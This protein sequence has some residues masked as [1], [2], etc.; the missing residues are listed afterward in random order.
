MLAGAYVHVHTRFKLSSDESIVWFGMGSFAL[1]LSIQELVKLVI[2]KRHVNDIRTIFMFVGL[3]TVLIDTQI[4][5][6]V[7][8]YQ[9]VCMSLQSTFVMAVVEIVL[10]WS[11]VLKL[12]FEMR[13]Y[14]HKL[15]RRF[16]KRP[17]NLAENSVSP[18][19]TRTDSRRLSTRLKLELEQWRKRLQL[20][21]AAEAFADMSAEYIAIGCSA[22]FL[23]AFG[24]HPN[25]TL[26]IVVQE[27]VKLVI[28]KRRVN[29]I[30]TI[31]L[32][33]GLPTV[34]IDT[35]IRLAMQRYQSASMSLLSSVLMAVVE[36]TLRWVKVLKLFLEMQYY[37]RR[38]VRQ[39]GG[40]THSIARNAIS[41]T[42]ND[43]ED[44]SI[45]ITVE[46]Q[47]WRQRLHLFHD[48]EVFADMS[49][50]YIAIGCSALFLYAF[51]HHPKY[52]LAL[53]TK[54]GSTTANLFGVQ[55]TSSAIVWI[56]LALEVVIDL[57]STTLE[58]PQGVEFQELRKHRAYIAMSFLGIGLLNVQVS[59]LMYL[60]GDASAE[61]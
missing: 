37:E 56:Q 53:L 21:H 31:F 10:R 28:L 14:E 20:F 58:I 2:L 19:S 6:V 11:K 39:L 48:A 52:E 12:V 1:K 44:K 38:L 4:R 8:R 26:K 13:Y 33:V 42:A 25:F 61:C 18:T 54:H 27:I 51:R 23:H 57:V 17:S 43:V 55:V 60:K 30:R 16:A 29:D 41:P 46:V 50:E 35:Q 47:K 32:S 5:L 24:H 45:Q 9:S 15:V 7:Q 34:L 36:I 49:A 22:L 59:S 3:P 40:Q